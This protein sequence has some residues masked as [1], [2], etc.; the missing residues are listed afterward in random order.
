MHFQPV[1]N[2]S[3]TISMNVFRNMHSLEIKVKSCT[4]IYR[5]TETSLYL[6]HP[7]FAFH[8]IKPRHEKTNVLVSDQVQR[9]PGCT[10]TEDG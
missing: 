6:S 10:A 5:N 4:F 8:I 2:A 3:Y 7:E 1:M 9:K